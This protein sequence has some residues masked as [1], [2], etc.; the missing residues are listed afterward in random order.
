MI[1]HPGGL[2]FDGELM[3]NNKKRV[4]NPKQGLERL[5]VHE[6]FI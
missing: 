1:Q 4:H 5:V 6:G 3:R 2:N